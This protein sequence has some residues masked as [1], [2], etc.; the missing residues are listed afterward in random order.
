[1]GFGRGDNVRPNP[2]PCSSHADKTVLFNCP[3]PV[4]ARQL[5]RRKEPC[6]STQCTAP[7]S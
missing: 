5:E 2:V 1:M 6:T 7:C 3:S 4:S